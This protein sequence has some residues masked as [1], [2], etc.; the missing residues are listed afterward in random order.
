[1]SS[2]SEKIDQ[3]RSF[4]IWRGILTA[5]LFSSFLPVVQVIAQQQTDVNVEGKTYS[6]IEMRG[7]STH[8]VQLVSPEGQ[9]TMI[10]VNRNNEITAILNPPAGRLNGVDYAPLIKKVW[11]AY[12]AQKNGSSASTGQAA[13]TT[14]PADDPNAARRAQVDAL[15]AQAQARAAGATSTGP[16]KR[17]VEFNEAGEAI[18]T[19]PDIKAK[20]KI[21]NE[22]LK[23]KGGSDVTAGLLINVTIDP[24]R[25]APLE[26]ETWRY[27]GGL[28]P[29]KQGRKFGHGL[30]GLVE[31]TANSENARADASVDVCGN[32]D[33][34]FSIV[35]ESGGNKTKNELGGSAQGK[36]VATYGRDP[37]EQLEKKKAY[38][39]WLDLTAA[40][41]EVAKS[42][43][44]API[45]LDF[46]SERYQR[47]QAALDKI[48][49][50]FRL[51]N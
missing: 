1:M 36:Y 7:G 22:V 6:V 18:V 15:A 39:L 43:G 35:A 4:K 33:N 46:T 27:E 34:C 21:S 17:T 3:S 2:F 30:R 16:G 48:T 49:K 13:P 32:P 31:A 5:A 26:N 23:G 14:P 40:R 38:F 11:A 8:M 44:K 19:D 47:E 29:A 45:Q 24:G 37:K 28:E 9:T 20:V 51:S 50:D 12:Q 10:S 41:E 42:G 25:G